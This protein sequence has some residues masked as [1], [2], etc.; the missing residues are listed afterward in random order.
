MKIESVKIAN[1]CEEG[2]TAEV[3]VEASGDQQQVFFVQTTDGEYR[4]DLGCWILTP[5]SDG[6]INWDDYPD[7]DLHAVVSAAEAYMDEQQQLEET[8]D[9][10]EG[11][12]VYTQN[13]RRVVENRNYTNKHQSSY[14]LKW[15]EI[16]EVEA[17]LN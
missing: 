16:E 8:N 6:D 9:K 13:G 15:L 14:R 4:V 11:Q 3:T 5:E 12:T 7:Y 17:Q 2:T 1:F 10:H